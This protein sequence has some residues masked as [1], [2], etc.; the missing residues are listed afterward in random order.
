M[1]IT[2]TDPNNADN[3]GSITL[4]YAYINSH[5]LIE[6][7]EFADGSSMDTAAILLAAEEVVTITNDSISLLAQSMT[8]FGS[9]SSVSQVSNL[10]A[11]FESQNTLVSSALE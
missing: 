5:Y 7:I 10:N 11:S 2:V 4:E 6:R 8:S 1:L 3:N 9:D